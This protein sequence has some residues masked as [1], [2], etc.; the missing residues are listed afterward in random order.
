MVV[1]ILPIF[2]AVELGASAFSIALIDGVGVVVAALIAPFAGRW[3]ARVSPLRLARL[4]YGLSSVAKGALAVAVTPVGAMEV[5]ALDRFGK[6][7]RDA[8][9]DLL[10]LASSPQR[11]GKA[12]G[13]QQAMDKLGGVLGPLAGLAV[14]RLS[15][16]SFDTVFVMAMV[17]CLVSVLIL[18]VMTSDTRA[19][20]PEA[21]EPQSKAGSPSRT[22]SSF[23]PEMVALGLHAFGALSLSLLVL[24]AFEEAQ[25]ATPVLLAFALLRA[26]TSLSSIPA[27]LGAD[28]FGPAILVLAGVVVWSIGLGLG[29]VGFAHWPLVVLPLVGIGEG[30]LRGPSKIWI[31]QVTPV[32]QRGHAL[33]QLSAI[34][35]WGGLFGGLLAGLVWGT[36]GHG[37]FA[38]SLA[39]QVGAAVVICWLLV[40]QPSK[41][42]LV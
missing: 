41:Q 39:A 38:V 37:A 33:G 15:A 1:P 8:P 32:S 5:R 24:A 20:A 18:F 30:L 14:F 17:P 2:L 35:S 25:S 40:R 26:T 10:L 19:P 34:T 3:S 7:I 4:G 23:K 31:T 13:I 22:E 21:L 36:G 42:R 12:I 9:R 27:G 16:S 28:R 11:P 6:G 29:L